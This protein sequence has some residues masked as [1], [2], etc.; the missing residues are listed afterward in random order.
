MSRSVSRGVSADNAARSIVQIEQ[1]SKLKPRS[2]DLGFSFL[3]RSNYLV[4]K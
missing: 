2:V 3:L 1:D 4:E